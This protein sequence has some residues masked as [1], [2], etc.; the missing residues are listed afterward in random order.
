MP[1]LPGPPRIVRSHWRD[2]VGSGDSASGQPVERDAVV[3]CGVYVDGEREGGTESYRGALAHARERG[4]FVWIGLHEPTEAQL[5]DIA[6]EFGLHPL[7]VEDAVVAHQRPKLERYEG[8]LF[9]V[10][11][12][13]RY[14][15]HEAVTET[16]QIVESG[17]VM[18]FIGDSFVVTVRHG[19]HGELGEIRRRLENDEELVRLGPMAVLYAVA[20]RIVDDYV[21][22]TEALQDDVDEIEQ[23]VLSPARTREIERIYQLK[24][25]VLELKHA[26]APLELPLRIL[27]SQFPKGKGSLKAYFRDVEDHLTRVREQVTGYDELL[28]SILQVAFAQVQ[29]NENEDMR[30]ISAWVA[31]AAVPT[32][33]AGIY[34]MNFDHMPELRWKYGYPMVLFGMAF[35]CGML[36]RGFKRNRWL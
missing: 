19:E 34:G 20:D 13:V 23:S 8:M 31:I 32:M 28:T 30:K 35:V 21:T 16:S 12:T 17:E 6:E 14:V 4:G 33:V 5:A 29:I 3:D 11:K 22:V 9:A 15:P 1:L 26:V 7:A 27:V 18:T 25:E 2:R 10:F 24:R 36:Y